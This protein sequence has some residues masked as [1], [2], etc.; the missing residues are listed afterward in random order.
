MPTGSPTLKRIPLPSLHY[1]SFTDIIAYAF[2][3]MSFLTKYSVKCSHQYSNNEV[4]DG[5]RHFW[6][7]CKHKFWGPT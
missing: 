4:G 2:H 3:D 7:Q 6:T 5:L 1:T